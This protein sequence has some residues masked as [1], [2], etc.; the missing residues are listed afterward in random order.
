MLTCLN[1]DLGPFHSEG[2]WTFITRAATFE[3]PRYGGAIPRQLR[4][5][6]SSLEYLDLC[7]NYLQGPIPDGFIAMDSLKHLDLSLNDLEGDIPRGYLQTLSLGKQL[8]WRITSFLNQ[9]YKKRS[10][11]PWG[12]QIVRSL[13]MEILLASKEHS[14]LS[15]NNLSGET[16]DRATSLPGLIGLNLSHDQ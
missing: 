5:L 11:R 15:C 3:L 10:Y 9:L 1:L 14:D 16:P 8:I 4:N 12:E 13:N 6:S 7:D 2:R